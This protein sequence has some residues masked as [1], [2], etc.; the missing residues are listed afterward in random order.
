MMS[1]LKNQ[2][3][4]FQATVP[5]QPFVLQATTLSLNPDPKFSSTDLKDIEQAYHTP[6]NN[7]FI[8]ILH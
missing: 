1:L 5:E 6:L 3:A 7:R 2:P 8:H 4:S